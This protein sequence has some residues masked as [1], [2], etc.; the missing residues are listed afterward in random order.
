ME[1]YTK[2]EIKNI[3]QA[4]TKKNSFTIKPIG[5]HELKRNLVYKI[6]LE[7][8]EVMALKIYFKKNKINREVAALKLLSSS[9]VKCTKLIR[10]GSLEDKTEW[11]LCNWI[12]GE[13]FEKVQQNISF[14]NQIKI[15]ESMGEELGKIHSFK[16][17][18]FFGDWDENGNSIENIKNS[19]ESF[20]Y[21]TESYAKAILHQHLP[22]EKLLIK[23]INKI[24]EN[25][26]IVKEHKESCLRHNDFD[27]RNILVKKIKNIWRLEGIIDFEQSTPGNVDADIVGLYHK[28]FLENKR[29]EEAFLRGYYKYANIDPDFYSKLNFYLLRR[30]VGICSW[31]FKSAPNYYKEGLRLIKQFMDEPIL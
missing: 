19:F 9:D 11:I 15:F 16:C 28:Y 22:E 29:Y 7:N 26:D 30:G 18:D 4:I 5:N 20:V 3:V 23:A 10:Y 14:E 25:Y 17:F 21:I 6:T 13:P 12:D 1:H 27:G 24:R 31:A 8:K 2:E